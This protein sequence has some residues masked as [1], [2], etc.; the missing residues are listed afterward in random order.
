ME[1]APRDAHPRRNHLHSVAESKGIPMEERPAAWNKSLV[2]SV[3][4]LIRVGYFERVLGMYLGED[5][6]DVPAPAGTMSVQAMPG[7]F[8]GEPA[9]G[10][11]CLIGGQSPWSTAVQ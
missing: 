2:E 7:G 1:P 4:P 5:G 8:R 10:R 3:R 6:E 9:P 11:L